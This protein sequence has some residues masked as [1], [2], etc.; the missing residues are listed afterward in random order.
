VRRSATLF[1]LL[2][3]RVFADM[4]WDQTQGSPDGI[5]VDVLGRVYCTGPGGI[6]VFMPDG[7]HFGTISFPK[8]AVNFA[9]GDTDLR[10]LFCCAQDCLYTLRVKVPGQPHPWY[11]PRSAST[12]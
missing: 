1:L 7:R 5:K 12:R 4:S 11:R 8:P 6:W 10:P 9:F 3:R 2:R